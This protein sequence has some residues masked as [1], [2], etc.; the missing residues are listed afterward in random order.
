[1]KGRKKRSAG[2]AWYF[3][4][5]YRDARKSMGRLPIFAMAIVLGIAAI[6]SINGFQ[7]D[8]ERAMD[9]EALS[10]MGADLEIEGYAPI[11]TNKLGL[12][13][14]YELEEAQARHFASM[15]SIEGERKGT[16]LALIQAIGK[17]F[18][19][20]G[21]IETKPS[22][23]DSNY[24]NRGAA[25]V[26]EDLMKQFGLEKGDTIKVGR[27]RFPI[28]GALLRM[29]GQNQLTS[30]IA[31]PIVIPLDS[32]EKTGL[33]QQG[34]RIEYKRYYRFKDR[35]QYQTQRK[36]L[37]DSLRSTGL[38]YETV[39]QQK[40]DMGDAFKNLTG[41]LNLVGFIALILGCIGVGSSVHIYMK[42]KTASVA[43]L[44]CIGAT[45][46]SVLWIFSVQ[47]AMI[48]LFA[49][50]I[51]SLIGAFLQTWM[52]WIMESL[53]PFTLSTSF[54]WSGMLVGM[55]IGVLFAVLFALLPLIEVSGT[56]PMRA[57][58]SFS[59]D[60]GIGRNKGRWKVFSVIACS[61][62][63]FALYQTGSWIAAIA[64][65]GGTGFLLAAL[66]GTGVFLMR[67][68][69]RL[70]SRHWS[71]SLR[72]GVAN[73][74]RPNGQTLVLV[75]AIG[76]ATALVSTLLLARGM[77]VERA[78]LTGAEGQP[79]TIL[80]DIQ[81]DQR[82][83]VLDFMEEEGM[84]VVQ[85]VPIVPMQIRSIE[86]KERA[87]ILADTTNERQGHM[88]ERE[89]R[90]T[91]R[92]SLIDT[93]NLVRGEWIGEAST[94]SGA[95]PVSLEEDVFQDLNLELGDHISFNVQG[96]TV[97]TYVASVREIEWRRMQTNFLVLFP[98]GVLENAPRTHAIMT[99]MESSHIKDNARY[100]L[101][102]R[103]PNISVIDL[104]RILES[105]RAVLEKISFAIRFMGSFSIVTGIVILIGSLLLT[106]YQR[107]R[108]IVL[109]RT[110]GAERADLL[111]IQLVE[112]AALGTI[113]S[114]SGILLGLGVSWTLAFFWFDVPMVIPFGSLVGIW[115]TVLFITLGLG[116]LN[117][118]APLRQAPFLVLRKG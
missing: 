76:L 73:L 74:F 59:S 5:A 88:V 75:L 41:Y 91:Y 96:A 107:L 35:S 102:Q 43:V 4:M 23:A 30:A 44:R 16:R 105:L 83:S 80:F 58:N 60:E 111:R 32:L 10:L 18:P 69:R 17:G 99:R 64:F 78:K 109:L 61:I 39:T 51:G 31:T 70:F 57:L 45:R 20:Y 94:D 2:F 24:R 116:I 42:E 71:F 104:E 40:E 114:A 7:S 89:Y 49:A 12:L 22:D 90:V 106:K 97:E 92:D 117:A 53:L 6:V 68:A 103:F 27:K 112:Y 37:E 56:S 82:D 84:S 8:L 55:G 28:S 110:L 108:E 25:L 3:L 38:D 72:Q 66:L 67:I 1:M 113:A 81:V 46:R 36:A 62:Y 13:K 85:D 15:V 19:F 100:R 79:N 98:K 29:P 86:G 48:G 93:E 77:L 34:S 26:A 115:G 33:V 50:L 95:I 54:S 52:P 14:T 63:L 87:S 47:I 21:E 101:V 11:D 9:Q 65:F 118:R